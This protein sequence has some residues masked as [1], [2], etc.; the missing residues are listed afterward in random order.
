MEAEGWLPW[1]PRAGNILAPF[2]LMGSEKCPN[3]YCQVFV[4][5]FARQYCSIV[6]GK[7]VLLRANLPASKPEVETRVNAWN[8]GEGLGI[9]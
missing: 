5:S 3:L 1:Q 2:V 8:V 4:T 9:P 7:H 6:T